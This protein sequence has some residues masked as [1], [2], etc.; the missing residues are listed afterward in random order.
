MYNEPRFN[1]AQ[2]DPD[3]ANLLRSTAHEIQSS[4]CRTR[5]ALGKTLKNAKK[6][7]AQTGHVCFAQWVYQECCMSATTAR[8]MISVH[9]LIVNNVPDRELIEMLPASLAYEIAKPTADQILKAAVLSGGITTHREYKKLEAAKIRIAQ[10]AAAAKM[11]LKTAAAGL[12]RSER[13]RSEFEAK[14][15]QAQHNLSKSIKDNE[16]LLWK[17]FLLTHKNSVLA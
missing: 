5:E 16:Q 11:M 9:E 6:R 12:T 17:L 8:N 13:D 14:Q 2:V 15:K 4:Q 7:L 3:T 1:Y 10:D